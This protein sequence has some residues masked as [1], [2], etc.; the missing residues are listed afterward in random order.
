MNNLFLL[1]DINIGGL[2]NN[3]S[4]QAADAIG[5]IVI[6]LVLILFAKKQIGAMIGTIIIGGFVYIVIKG[7]DQILNAIGNFFKPI[8]GL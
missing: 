1:G 6:V 7:P 4:S 8:F 5:I 2:S 3:I